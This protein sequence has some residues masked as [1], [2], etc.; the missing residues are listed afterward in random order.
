[1]ARHVDTYFD[2]WKATL[3]DPE[4]LARFVSF[5]NA[6]DAPDPQHHLPRGAGADRTRGLVLRARSRSAPPSRSGRRDDPRVP[7]RPDRGRGR[8]RGR[9]STARRWR[10]SGPTRVRSS[11]SRT[12]ILSQGL[13]AGSGHRRDAGRHPVRGLA[14]AQAGL[15]PAHR[16]VPRRRGGP[17]PD[18]RRPGSTDGPDPEVLVG[19]RRESLLE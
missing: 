15:R 4:K 11:R 5:V 9:W 13:G 19:R 10:S 14:H 8:G 16:T 3:D 18:V 2:E 17:G 7:A 12:T 6:P 1:M